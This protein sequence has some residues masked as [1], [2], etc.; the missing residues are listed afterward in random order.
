MSKK[1]RL[2]ISIIGFL[3]M[4]TV[5]GFALAADF[6]VEAVNSGLAGSLSDADPRIIVGRI[7]QIILS[8]L[9]VIA[10]VII[11]YAG[12]LWMTSN[13]EE[14]KVSRAK[15]ILK[16][17]VIGLIIILSSW[18]IATFILSRLGAATGSGQFDGSN[19]AGVGSTYPGLGAIGACSVESVYPSDGQDDVP[20]N[21]SIMT[22]F[23]EKIQLNSVC[24]NSAGTAC[25]CD[26]SDCNKINPAAIRLYKT[27]LG[28]ACTS[29]CPE[30]NGNITAVSVTVTGDDRVLILTPVDLLG[31]PTDKI[32]YSVKFTDAVKKLDGSSMFKNCAADLVAWRFVVSSR[33]DLTPPLIV[34]AG[35]FPLPDNEKDLYQAIT[36]AQAATGAITVNVAPRIYSAAAVQKITSLPAGLA[37]ELVLD[38][39]GSIAAFKLTVPADAPNKIQLFDEA[40]NLLGLAEFD[41]EGVAVFENYFT[42][43]AIDHPAGSLWQVNIKPEV[44]ADTLTVNNTVYTFAATAE[45]N[46]IRVPAPFAADKQAAYIAAKINGLE[47]QA[48]AAGRIINMQAKVAGA[49]GNSLLVTTSNNTALTIKPLSGGVDRQE[50]S[51]TN[52]KK[53]RPM[54]SAIQLNFNEAINPATVSGL[55]ADVFDRIRVVNAVDSY[56]AGTA[57]TANAQCQSYKCENGQCVGNHV[58]GKFVV[59]NNYRTVEFISDVKCGVNGCGEEIYCLPANS[60]LAIEVVPA[61]LQTCETSEDCLAFSPFKICSATG[62][63]Y[64]TCQNEI[65]KNY[66]VA[67]LSLLDGIVDAAVNSFDGNRDAYADGPLD[68]YNDN[69]EPQANIGLK[70]KYRWSFYVSDQIRLTPSQI[71]VV[72]PA[73][74]QAGLSLA[75]PIK[76]SFNTLM[77]NS[78]LRTGRISVPSGTSTVAHQAVNLRSTSPNPLGYWISADNQDTPPLDG[79]PDLTVMSIFHSPFQ[80]SVTYQAQVGS[81]VKDIY[82]NCYKPSAGPGCLVTAEQPSCCFGVATDTLGADGSCQ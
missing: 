13:G 3:A 67:N 69:Y 49:A 63:N 35:I 58:G 7:I 72:M 24:V 27:D 52:D 32:G 68:F 54:N 29:V 44:L 26:Q 21:T 79:E 81:G 51:Q 33:L 59:S 31:S 34:P 28:D 5:A 2:I 12:F 37:A 9:G 60:H 53:D 18:G 19:T 4:L 30:I 55:A 8:F 36:P 61:N 48:V 38:Y 62:F 6:G 80:E 77:M 57:C 64:K 41:A 39:H 76:V 40:D 20:R 70:D 47:I 71:T 74:G 11:M 65:G 25:A 22:T 56:S 14:E 16:N 78:S 23:K 43:K 82:Q 73:Q 45:N 46:F 50:S 10:V 66:P 1:I 75:E 15:N 42:F 17:A